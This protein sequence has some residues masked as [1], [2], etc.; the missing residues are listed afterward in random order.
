MPIDFDMCIVPNDHNTQILHKVTPLV[1]LQQ[2]AVSLGD[3][4]RLYA[5]PTTFINLMVQAVK[6]LQ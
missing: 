3:T 5:A 1:L 2:V 6:F 4:R